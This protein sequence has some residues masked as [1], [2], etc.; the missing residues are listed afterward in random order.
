MCRSFPTQRLLP[1]DDAAKSLERAIT[2]LRAAQA[3]ILIDA[4]RSGELKDS[5]CA[6]VRTFAAT[7][8]RRSAN[9]AS[10]LAR[11][12]QHLVEL[13]MLA[14]AYRAG[15]VSTGSLRVIVDHLRPLWVGGVA[16]QRGAAGR[17]RAACRPG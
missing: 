7:V 16:G 14:Q 15:E 13:P 6:T 3:D 12:A 9:D 1:P 5:A 10:A 8:L 2:T 4:E 17:A 11:V